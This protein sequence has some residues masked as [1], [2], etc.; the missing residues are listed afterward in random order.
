[1]DNLG[2]QKPSELLH[3][4]TVLYPMGYE[5]SPFFLFLLLQRSLKELRIVL[6]DV[7]AT[8]RCKP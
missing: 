5:E 4:M 2:G 1:M 7:D 8:R 3:E 6:G